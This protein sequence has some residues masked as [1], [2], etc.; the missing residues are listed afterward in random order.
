MC[1]YML[2]GPI[3]EPSSIEE[4]QPLPNFEDI[5]AVGARIMRRTE[6]WEAIVPEHSFPLRIEGKPVLAF[7]DIRRELPGVSTCLVQWVAFLPRRRT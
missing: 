1:V 7:E 6:G 4:D 2:A 5:E 3:P